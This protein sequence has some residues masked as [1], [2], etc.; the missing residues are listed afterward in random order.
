MGF[1]GVEARAVLDFPGRAL[2]R[3]RRLLKWL[4]KFLLPLCL[5]GFYAPPRP[6]CGLFR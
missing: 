4:L 3:E 5:L 1:A 2:P 6:G